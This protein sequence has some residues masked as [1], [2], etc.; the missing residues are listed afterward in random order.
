[1]ALGMH[2]LEK[3]LYNFKAVWWSPPALRS[4]ELGYFRFGLN[5]VLL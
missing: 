3:K 4:R 1:M 5:G 2:S